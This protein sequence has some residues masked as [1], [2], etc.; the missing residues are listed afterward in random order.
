MILEAS[1]PLLTLNK[2]VWCLPKKSLVGSAWAALSKKGFSKATV[3]WDWARR[4]LGQ[5]TA[6]AEECPLWQQRWLSAQRTPAVQQ[7]PHGIS[8]LGSPCSLPA[9]KP[10]CLLCEKKEEEERWV[11]APHLTA[12]LESSCGTYLEL[13]VGRK[14]LT[15]QQT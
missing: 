7:V 1:C 12:E 11:P 8:G 3:M 10:Q 4:A 14:S 13:G 9:P 6:G 2:T 5:G 15:W